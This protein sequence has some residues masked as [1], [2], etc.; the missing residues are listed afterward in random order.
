MPLP[1]FAEQK[2]IVA[3]IEKIFKIQTAMRSK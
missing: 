1:P 2:R 3:E